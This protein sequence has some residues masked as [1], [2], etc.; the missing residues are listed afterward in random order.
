MNKLPLW[1]DLL[2]M[3]WVAGIA[4]V[5]FGGFFVPAIG[6]YTNNAAALYA[7]MLLI[8]MISVALRFLH[9]EGTPQANPDKKTKQD[10][11]IK[12]K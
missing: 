7:L 1:A 5:Y 6:A 11:R 12:R 8:S 4:A 3:I 9:R 2:L 10:V